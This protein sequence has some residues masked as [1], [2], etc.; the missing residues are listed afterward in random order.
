M[1]A[2]HL[3][4]FGAEVIL[5]CSSLL[6]MLRRVLDLLSLR[7]A[8]VKARSKTIGRRIYAF[9]LIVNVAG[10]CLNVAA[11]IILG[12]VAN[13]SMTLSDATNITQ[14][15]TS[16][17]SPSSAAACDQ[18]LGDRITL[19]NQL[20]ATQ[21][22][23]ETTVMIVLMISFV[24]SCY[25]INKVRVPARSLTI[26]SLHLT[27]PPHPLH[28]RIILALAAVS[29]LVIE[30]SLRSAQANL[31]SVQNRIRFA[32]VFASLCFTLRA[33]YTGFVTF[34]EWRAPGSSDDAC[35]KCGP[36][37]VQPCTGI[38]NACRS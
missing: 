7:D 29:S 14:S 11:A 35:A 16:T 8:E 25:Y 18:Q 26:T 21:R 13:L 34:A 6:I 36:C 32:V 22:R 20:A 4:F 23:C 12:D 2:V 31:R 19:V 17:C 27:P 15:P 5:F 30:T 28:Q 9:T 33:L 3:P 10:L 24:V 38:C 1:R 37:Q